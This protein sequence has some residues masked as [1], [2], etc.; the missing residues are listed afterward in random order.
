MLE[1]MPDLPENV[2]GFRAV[3]TVR[4]EDYRDVLTPAVLD[5]INRTGEASVLLVLGPE[6][7]GYSP[8]AMFEDAKL[9]VE[10]VRH[11]HRFALV[12]DAHWIH[13]VAGMFN[14]ITPGEVKAFYYDQLPKATQWVA[15]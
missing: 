4:A 10:K 11:W 8:G 6:W 13:H 12:S 15:G 7:D 2:V 1:V 14:W 9:G 5:L 3:D